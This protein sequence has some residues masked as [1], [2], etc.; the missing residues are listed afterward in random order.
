MKS[1]DVVQCLHYMK[2]PATF[3]HVEKHHV[4]LAVISVAAW[5]PHAIHNSSMSPICR[6]PSAT[7]ARYMLTVGAY[8]PPFGGRL[9][10]SAGDLFTDAIYYASVTSQ[11]RQLPR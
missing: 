1:Y 2:L 11:R 4:V 8:S 9:P 7:L 10:P 6:V 3:Q 5:F